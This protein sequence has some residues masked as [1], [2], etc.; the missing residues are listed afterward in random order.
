MKIHAKEVWTDEAGTLHVIEWGSDNEYKLENFVNKDPN[1][2]NAF[3]GQ[4]IPRTQFPREQN[5]M[6]EVLQLEDPKD[7]NR[8]DD[9]M[10][11]VAPT[12]TDL[13]RQKRR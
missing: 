9:V 7:K 6:V 1:D 13:S 3:M 11:R 12:G 2:P 5:A 10:K 4:A 8:F